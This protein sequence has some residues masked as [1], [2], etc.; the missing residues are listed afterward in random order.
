MSGESPW[1]REVLRE[2]LWGWCWLAAYFIASLALV[3]LAPSH[4]ALQ[5]PASLI[6]D[7]SEWWGSEHMRSQW[8]GA[9]ASWY[10]VS[11]EPSFVS[12][13]WQP[14]ADAPFVRLRVC[15]EESMAEELGMVMLA[16]VNSGRLDFNRHYAL[17]SVDGAPAGSCHEDAFPRWAGDGL[18]VIQVQTARGDEPVSLSVLDVAP[19]QENPL[20]LICRYVMLPLGVLL[21]AL[22]FYG[23]ASER[24]RFFSWG[25]LAGLAAILFG[26]TV[27]VT[28]KADIYEL[29]TGG[30]SIAA[31]SDL[32]ELLTTRF[33][34]GGFSIFTNLHTVLFF[35]TTLALGLAMQGRIGRVFM[36]MVLLAP[37]TECLQI[38]VPGRGPGFLDAVADWQGVLVAALLVVLLLRS[39]RV[40]SLLKH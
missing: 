23:Y 6:E 18:S 30:R 29:F 19:L 39:Q 7:P 9:V 8:D 32:R 14:P 3:V 16:S 36:D 37:L 33:P 21:I 31:E 12:V 1:L 24:P 10:S 34:I 4:L 2:V 40:R 22:R 13:A 38:F 5:E 27:S 11:D 15:L 35:G 26:C 28:L 20:W 25:G 17:W